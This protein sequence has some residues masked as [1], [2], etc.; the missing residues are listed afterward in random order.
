MNLF[1]YSKLKLTSVDT[2]SLMIKEA[3]ERTHT[4]TKKEKTIK[5][6]QL[7]S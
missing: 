2:I 5:K 4:H 7:H 3:A 1:V 6:P